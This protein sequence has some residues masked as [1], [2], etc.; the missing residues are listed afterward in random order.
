M[1]F[2]DLFLSFFIFAKEMEM[3]IL[4]RNKRE[5]YKVIIRKLNNIKNKLE[6]NKF[7]VFTNNYITLK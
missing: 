3:L 6:E 4:M 5:N 7:K 2:V 1:M